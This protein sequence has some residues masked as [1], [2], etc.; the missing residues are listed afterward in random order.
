MDYLN[1]M[2][3]DNNI[4]ERL[5]AIRWFEKCGQPPIQ[6]LEFGITW[7]KD[8]QT[9]TK[10]FSDPEWQNTT[11]EARNML[12]VHLSK[13][14]AKEYQDWNKLVRDAKIKLQDIFTAIEI[15][16]QKQGLNKKFSDCARWDLLAAVMESTYKSCHPPVF[17]LKLLTI[18]ENGHYPCGWQG[19]WPNGNLVVI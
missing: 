18:Y 10:Y 19:E 15:F 6:N 13:K 8:W 5:Q 1:Y 12:T 2:Q 3:L 14:H 11:L 7:I 9:A 16:Q 4:F 17:F